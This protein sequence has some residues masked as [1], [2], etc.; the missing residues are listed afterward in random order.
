MNKRDGDILLALS[1]FGYSGQRELAL[2]C[3]CSLGAVN[4]S[5][6]N[7]VK[8]GFLNSDFRMTPKGKSVI[9]NS[10]PKR[11]VILAAG[12]GVS[13]LPNN[14]KISKA[15]LTVNGQRL[16]DRLIT[17]LNEVGI[18]EIYVVV[19]FGKESFEYLID[20]YGV[21]LIVNPQYSKKNNLHSLAL[22][23]E[24]LDNC[25]ILPCDL[26][27][28]ENPF[29]KKELYSWYMVSEEKSIESSVRINLKQELAVVPPLEYGNTMIGISYLLKSDAEKIR[30][31]LRFMD[32]DRRYEGA[33]WEE[34]L[35]EDGKFLV[36]ARKVSK[37]EVVEINDFED[38]LLID[39]KLVIPT[40]EIASA[41]GVGETEITDITPLKRGLVNRSYSFN[42][43]GERYFVRIPLEK[44]SELLDYKREAEIYDKIRNFSISDEVIYLNGSSGLKISRYIDNFRLCDSNNK[45]DVAICMKKLREIHGLELVSDYE[46]DLFGAIEQIEKISEGGKSVYSDYEE[47]RKNVF[48]LKSFV[49]SL[50]KRSVLSHLDAVWENFM[51]FEDGIRLIDWEYSATV[52][53]DMDIAMFAV[54]ALYEKEQIDFLIDSYFEGACSNSTR[55]KI[56]CYIAACGLLWSNWCERRIRKGVE[57]GE[58]SLRQYRYAKDYFKIARNYI[59]K[60]N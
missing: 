17:Q 34:T 51:M 22:G 2:V 21:R 40:A 45:T 50:P 60:E 15:L 19:G 52:D 14:E 44:D 55:A 3:G 57:F 24:F 7:L 16:I 28:R 30:E 43:K 12:V 1:D 49:E 18:F 39:S 59:E 29:R 35:Y 42:C 36:N 11:A 46:F 56:Y 41:L 10:S 32:C 4:A 20:I 23:S 5:V 37:N 33:F 6:N 25:Y 8:D 54:Y 38:L 26:W 58:Y 47:T 48:S 31:R 13:T 53:P 9:R 27:C